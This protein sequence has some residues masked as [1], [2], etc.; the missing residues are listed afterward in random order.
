M[1]K[2]LKA[3]KAA[4]SAQAAAVPSGE[5]PTHFF[6]AQLVG[7]EP[8]T[9]QTAEKLYNLSAQIYA[10]KPWTLLA[11]QDLFLVRD[12][13]SG[14]IGY[15]S[16]MGALGQVL[17]LHIYLGGESY[18][19]FRR[20]A[21]GEQLAPEEFLISQTGI[22]V[23]FVTLSELT[24]PDRELLK[25]FG[26][27]LKRGSRAPM[28]RALR[29]GFHPWY[30]TEPEAIM[31]AE[32]M[33]ALMFLCAIRLNRPETTYWNQ[34]DLYPMIVPVGN[35]GERTF[36]IEMQEA[37]DPPPAPAPAP[38]TLDDARLRKVREKDYTVRGC[39][40]A[41]C[42]Y[43]PMMV[44]GKNERKAFARMGLITDAASG[45][46]FHPEIASA[47]KSVAEILMDVVLNVIDATRFIPS[48]LR[49]SSNEFKKLLDPVAQ[50][51]GISIRVVKSLPSLD[52][53]KRSMMS[54]MMGM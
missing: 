6:K 25:W 21:A 40:E 41:D 38:A 2:K 22:S 10:L 4:R 26:H 3:E 42:F 9:W 30:V 35:D 32:C 17:S 18:R 13:D 7:E 11:D 52:Q 8:L 37:G 45:F 5:R 51:L 34:E 48:E 49:V 14:E 33:A 36:Q 23:E 27:P 44:G 50:Q 12:P 16:V 39:F 53:A 28:F 20:I 19:S 46:L 15:C 31:L 54:M 43:M 24:P 1:P 29:S 47:E